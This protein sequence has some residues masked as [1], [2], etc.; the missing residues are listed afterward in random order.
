MALIYCVEDEENIR[1]LVGYA[2]KSQQF[3]TETFATAEAFWEALKKRPPSLVLLDIML[4]GEDGVSILKRL[5]RSV[6]YAA[7]PVIMLTA[8]SSE[9]DVVKGLDSGADD[10]IGK[11]FGIIELISRIRA[12]L[13]R[14]EKEPEKETSFSYENVTLDNTKH[15]VRVDGEIC[16]LTVKEFELLEYL[17]VNEHIVLR[18]EQIMEVVWGFTF[19]GESRT[20]DMHIRSLRQ[21]LGNGGQIIK[22]V[23]GVG[24]RIGGGS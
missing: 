5:K 13:R 7:I 11:P 24:Y 14:S 10:Y 12:V 6:E 18:R 23:R 1:E 8:K 19:E 22:T 21:K 17:L 16:R 9:Y 3:E 20:I 4:P 15:E 2:L